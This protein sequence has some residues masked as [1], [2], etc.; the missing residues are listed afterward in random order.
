MLDENLDATSAHSL[1]FCSQCLTEP[2]RPVVC[3]ERS[4]KRSVQPW[5]IGTA[6]KRMSLRFSVESHYVM[7]KLCTFLCITLPFYLHVSFFF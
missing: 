7:V 4:L 6:N 3:V 2:S 5:E 1:C